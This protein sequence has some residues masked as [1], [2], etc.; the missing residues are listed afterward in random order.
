MKELPICTFYT[1]SG[2]PSFRPKCSK[3]HKASK[4]CHEKRDDCEDYKPSLTKDRRVK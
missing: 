3:G 4:K 2:Y 1:T